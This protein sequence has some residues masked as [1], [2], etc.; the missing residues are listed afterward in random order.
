MMKE[1][2][3]ETDQ[4]IFPLIS[5]VMFLSMFVAALFWVY[6]KGGREVYA[7]RSQMVFHDGTVKGTQKETDHV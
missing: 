3:N 1:L 5:A 6:R 7:R 2:I 4:L